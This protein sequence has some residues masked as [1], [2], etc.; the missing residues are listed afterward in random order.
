MYHL[1]RGHSERSG[2]APPGCI[3]GMLVALIDDRAATRG[4]DRPL[5]VKAIDLKSPAMKS[6]KQ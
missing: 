5:A 4:M 6:G 2:Y 3:G 1:G